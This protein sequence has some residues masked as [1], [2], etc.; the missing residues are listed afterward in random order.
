[1]E[2]PSFFVGPLLDFLPAFFAEFGSNGITYYLKISF[3]QIFEPFFIE[4]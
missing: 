2:R 1:M 3:W 4:F